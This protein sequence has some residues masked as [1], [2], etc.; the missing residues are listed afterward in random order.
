MINSFSQI[1]SNF[2]LYFTYKFIGYFPLQNTVVKNIE[3]ENK[4]YNFKSKWSIVLDNLKPNQ[5]SY[6]NLLNKAWM[7]GQNFKNPELLNSNI[8]TLSMPT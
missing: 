5:N 6:Y 1:S 8:K 3:F 7:K 2:E 4:T